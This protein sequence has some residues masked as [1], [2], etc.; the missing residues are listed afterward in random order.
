[1]YR[2][3]YAMWEAQQEELSNLRALLTS[4]A[5]K[6]AIAS[7]IDRILTESWEP[8]DATLHRLKAA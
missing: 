6:D 3:T 8:I 7:N 4:G 1:M 5:D 2:Q